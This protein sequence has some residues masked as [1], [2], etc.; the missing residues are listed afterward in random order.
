MVIYYVK[1]KLNTGLNSSNMVSDHWSSFTVS[2]RTC[3]FNGTFVANHPGAAV[4]HASVYIR[5][6]GKKLVGSFDA[7]SVNGQMEQAGL[8]TL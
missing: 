7:N 6:V 1:T 5:R 4:S 3:I 8:N 2:S